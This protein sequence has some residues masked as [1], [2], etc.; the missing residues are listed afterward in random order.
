ME[1]L[2][3]GRKSR[4]TSKVAE[5][6]FIVSRD[7]EKADA[8]TRKLIRS[9]VMQGKKKRARPRKSMQV[10]AVVIQPIPKAESEATLAEEMR[11]RYTTSMP[12]R[13]GSDLSFIDFADD[14]ELSM[15]LNMMKIADVALGIIFPL[16]VVGIRVDQEKRLYP[17]Q[18]DAA[19][20][21]ISVYAVEDFMNKVLR[22]N[23]DSSYNAMI[24]YHKGL[25]ILQERLL[26][27]DEE[28][29][30]ADSTLGAILKLAS[31]AQ[32]CGDIQTAVQHM[33]GVYRIIDIR[34]GLKVFDGTEIQF[35][36]CRY[37]LSIALLNG[38]KPFFFTSEE[39]FIPY[40]EELLVS[41]DENI[42]SQE[43]TSFICHV[44][45]DLAV[46][47]RVLRRFCSLANLGVQT[48]RRMRPRL[49]L[50]TMNSVMYRL[51]H[52]EFA[53][54]SIDESIRFGL[55]AF[56]HHVF[57]QWHDIR[58]VDSYF[59]HTYRT[60]ILQSDSFKRLPPHLSLWFL[61]IAAIS[62][63]DVSVEMWLE[64]ALREYIEKT[65]LRKWKDVQEVMSSVMWVAVLDE[66][67][68]RRIFNLIRP[69]R[70]KG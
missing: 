57:L 60:R 63:F 41:D 18:G 21:H 2:N 27:D 42:S 55:L 14:I 65:G 28:A 24:H 38:L 64:D 17:I 66:Q 12:R 30:I 61:K 3:A 32:F 51:L 33:R 39:S 4:H 31:A 62:I 29:K 54:E 48:R 52:M 44:H 40:P 11:H 34:G 22:Y 23:R 50:D 19:A 59:S 68:V 35:E 67:P 1:R 56:S 13:V 6:P 25:R 43:H 49:I 26:G 10:Q 9:H 37:D 47:W 5:M 36:T 45:N 70:P 15:L 16:N 58:P 20:L 7:L 46:A 8:A 53:A 69:T